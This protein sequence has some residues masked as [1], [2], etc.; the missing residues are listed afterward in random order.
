MYTRFKIENFRCFESF[1][2]D[3]LKQFNLITGKN[4]VGKTVLLEA[5][6]IHHGYYNPNVAYRADI[7]RGMQYQKKDELLSDVFAGFDTTKVVCLQSEDEQA[8]AETLQI[9]SRTSQVS[10]VSLPKEATLD[11]DHPMLVAEQ[12]QTE[13]ST[14]T[15]SSEIVFDYSSSRGDKSKATVYV[16]GDQIMFRKAE[17]RPRPSGIFLAARNEEPHQAVAERLGT[18]LRD[19]LG[20]RIVEIA[21]LLE[22]ALQGLQI[23]PVAGTSVIF[24]DLGMPRWLPVFL[25]GDGM[26]RLLRIAV[27]ITDARKGLLLIDE[28][29]NGIHWSA[30][31]NVWSAV[32]ALAREYQVQVFATTHSWECICAAQR[33]FAADGLHDLAL[34]RLERD[35]S[36]AIRAM[37]LD[38]E[39]LA[40]SVEAGWE[41]R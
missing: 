11:A 10:R 17:V 7:F 15:E 14:S 21:R 29:E 8:I 32:A 34:H 40:V 36:G 22:P 19:K 35:R 41:V 5:L 9:K 38:E 1:A 31:Q 13:Y 2:I 6:W 12:P 33:A 30:I 18:M 27:G 3:G 26:M 37:T 4:G 20:D 24:G 25:M 16:Q 39:S 23:L 28:I